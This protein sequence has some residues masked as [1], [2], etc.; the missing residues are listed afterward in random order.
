[1]AD[2]AASR[3][4]ATPIG[5]RSADVGAAVEILNGW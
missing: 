2:L 4:G 1:V 3:G 5:S